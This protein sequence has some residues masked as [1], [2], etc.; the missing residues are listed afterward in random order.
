VRKLDFLLPPRDVA[1]PAE[2]EPDVPV[3]AELLEAKALSSAT[4][5]A[6]GNAT[7]ANACR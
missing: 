2:L 3:H 1:P 6:L 7:P 5:A 4:L